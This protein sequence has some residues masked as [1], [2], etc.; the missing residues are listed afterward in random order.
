MMIS[1]ASFWNRAMDQIYSNLRTDD[2][3]EFVVRETAIW[4]VNG[5]RGEILGVAPSLRLAIDKTQDYAVSGAAVVSICRLPRDSIIVF[6]PQIDRLRKIIAGRETLPI[7][8]TRSLG[9]RVIPL[10]SESS[11]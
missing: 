7:M 1:A 6:P 2:Q 11:L 4:T 3:L 8:E 5:P 10:E 9:G